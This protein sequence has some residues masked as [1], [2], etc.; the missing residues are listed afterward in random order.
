MTDTTPSDNNGRGPGTPLS[1]I[2]ASTLALV[3][4][5]LLVNNIIDSQQRINRLED[6]L[7]RPGP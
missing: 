1:T 2:I 4:A 6:A 5:A 3:L 7:L